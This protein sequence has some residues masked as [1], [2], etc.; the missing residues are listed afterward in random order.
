[1]A[2]LGKIFNSRLTPSRKDAKNLP[3]D[4]W[5]LG[6]LCVLC[7]REI[8]RKWPVLG[9]K[10]AILGPKRPENGFFRRFFTHFHLRDPLRLVSVDDILPE[11]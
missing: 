4:R 6:A 10:I 9:P 8:L 7:E 5:P 11:A 3:Q 2:E 1:M